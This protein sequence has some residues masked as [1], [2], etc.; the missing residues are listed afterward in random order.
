MAHTLALLASSSR[1]DELLDWLAR[2]TPS[3]AGLPLLTTAELAQR[4]RADSRT[5]QLPAKALEAVDAGGDVQL[6]ARVLTG[7]VALVVAFLE[8]GS[9]AG[10]PPDAQ[11][12]I[13]SCDLGAVP[14][15]LN[16][17][18]ADLALRGLAHGRTAYLL[19][20]P[21]AGQGN[22]NADLALIRSILE[23]QVLVNVLLT[24]PD[25]DPAEQTRELVHILQA[26]PAGEPGSAMIVACGGD[27]TGTLWRERWPAPAFPL[28]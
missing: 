12:L 13:R 17:A 25:V 10:T 2:Q 5:A 22:A 23:P 7:E 21:V 6:A 15:A 19:F 1:V 14:L 20:N 16:A 11:L 27:G 4:L 28:V 26:R 9:S 24:R 3:L 8:P 18:T